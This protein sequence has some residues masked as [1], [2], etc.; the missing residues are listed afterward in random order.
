VTRKKRAPPLYISAAVTR[1]NL[2][3]DAH[4]REKKQQNRIDIVEDFITRKKKKKNHKARKLKEMTTD[5]IFSYL[6]FTMN[7]AQFFIG[8]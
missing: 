7:A 2:R 6:E 1:G 5:S 8:Q 4:K 3:A